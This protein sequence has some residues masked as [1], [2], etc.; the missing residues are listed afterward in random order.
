MA[1]PVIAFVSPLA[2]NKG[3]DR[4]LEA[5]PLVRQRVPQARLRVMGDGPLAGLVRAAAAD[6]ARGVEYA[7]SG[8]AGAV[9]GF[10]RGAAVFATAPRATVKWS[11]QFGLAYLEALA[12]GL[13]I[14]TTATGTNQEAVPEGNLRVVD[15]APALADALVRMLREPARRADVGRANRA[16]AEAHHDL[17]VQTARMAD[18]FAAVEGC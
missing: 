6:P 12:S 5:L 13:P 17:R 18:A 11:E 9:A 3:I 10:L 4:V 8:D 7:G 1:D 15:T 2:A 14:V 16:Y